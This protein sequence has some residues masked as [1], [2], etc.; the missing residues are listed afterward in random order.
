LKDR[1]PLLQRGL[2]PETLP[3]CFT[4]EDLKRSLGGLVNKLKKASFYKRSTDY[5]VYNGTKHDGSRRYFGTP[6]PISYFYVASFIA[7][8]WATFENRYTASPF[9][10]SSPRLGSPTD[11]RPVV[12][13]SL[14]ELTTAA[15]KKLR[16]SAYVLKT[17][18]AQF[19]PSIYTHS[20]PWSAHGVAASKADQ[21]VDSK[22]IT[23]NRLDLFV[24]NCQRGETRGVLVG[25]DAFRIIAEYIAAGIDRE[26]HDR[27]SPHI[28]GAARHVDDYFIGLQGEPEALVAL[29]ELR[30]LLIK[31]NLNVNDT[32]TKVISGTEPLNEL[33]AQELR[34]EA[35][36][37]SSVAWL[38]DPDR[39]LAFLSKALSLSRTLS[40]DSPLKI[41]LRTL[42][43]IRLY[44]KSQWNDIEPYLQR[45]L[46]HHPHCID[47]I[48]LLVV[49]RVALGLEIDG[50][51]WQ[52]AS[53]SL[54][55][56]H[57]ALNH[58]HEIVWLTWLLIAAKLDLPDS[59]IQALST[60]NNAHVSSLVIAAFTKGRIPRKPPIRLGAKLA[61]TESNWLLNLVARSEG[62]T[63][64]PFSGALAAEFE[65]LA[66]KKV[67][68][69]DFESHVTTAKNENLRAISRTRY[70][71]DS[72]EYDDDQPDDED[73]D[74]EAYLHA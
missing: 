57:L 66:Q 74:L 22:A 8:N 12:I 32:K 61:T 69:I 24:R 1:Y 70:G 35:K 5:I 47:Y 30:D 43:Q 44:N 10:V 42:D 3:P 14:S 7:D 6:N 26:L 38:T 18:I 59:L 37:L 64:A 28:V 50:T 21:E 11:D 52:T 39:V 13:P 25:P 9:S 46:Y 49:K 29:S 23:F 72:D 31:F 62:Y 48:A 65:H 55:K 45:A 54:L 27:I 2:F 15:S 68:L 67:R 16:H 40:S 41:A 73:D 36:A 71:Y 34:L 58:H 4:S 63:K 20:I 56:R 19:F 33:W 53:H 51:G 17:D 60:S